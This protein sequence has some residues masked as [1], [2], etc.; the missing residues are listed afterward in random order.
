MGKPHKKKN[1]DLYEEFHGS[2]PTNHRKV[3]LPMPPKGSKLIVIGELK[4]LEYCPPG[5]SRHHG[6]QFYHDSGDLGHK[7][8]VVRTLLVTDEKGENIYILPQHPKYPYM[9]PNGIIG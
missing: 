9:S 5:N 3:S 2:S 1:P 7:K 6:I 8:V 4:R